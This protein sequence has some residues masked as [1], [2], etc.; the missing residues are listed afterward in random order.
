MRVLL[1]QC[2]TEGYLDFFFLPSFMFA[3]QCLSYTFRD[4]WFF[5]NINS[6]AFSPLMS[7]GALRGRASLRLLHLAGLEMT[8]FGIGFDCLENFFYLVFYL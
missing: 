1:I 7:L 6:H 2:H 5:I 4:G 3:S 8:V